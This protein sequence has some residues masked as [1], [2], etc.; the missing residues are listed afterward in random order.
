MASKRSGCNPAGGADN[1]TVNDLSGT[2]VKLVAIDLAAAGTIDGDGQPDVVTV[3]A[4]AGE[5]RDPGDPRQWCGESERA[6]RAGDDR[7]FR[8]AGSTN[9]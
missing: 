6:G 3:N 8:K 1:V 7:A 5:R 2:D 9:S 4:T